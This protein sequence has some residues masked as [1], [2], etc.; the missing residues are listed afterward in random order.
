MFRTRSSRPCIDSADLPDVLARYRDLPMV[1]RG[2]PLY[3]AADPIKRLG[4]RGDY[5]APEPG[6][7]D[8]SRSPT[9]GWCGICLYTTNSYPD[10]PSHHVVSDTTF[11]LEAIGWPLTSPPRA[12]PAGKKPQ[13][14][15]RISKLCP[16]ITGNRPHLRHILRI[17]RS[18]D[19]DGDQHL[20]LS[21]CMFA[22]HSP[23]TICYRTATTA[24]TVQA[25]LV[26]LG[27]ATSRL[28]R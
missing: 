3:W 11:V 2:Q 7:A 8:L 12:S 26:P 5:F 24:A 10:S 19:T 13:G 16:Q 1:R 14:G 21:P 20:Q 25:A 4:A 23:L 22:T 28:L 6:C 18:M 9:R 17:H 15:Q 27:G